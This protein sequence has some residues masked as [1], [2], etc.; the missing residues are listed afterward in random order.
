[1]VTFYVWKGMGVPLYIKVYQCMLPTPPEQTQSLSVACPNLHHSMQMGINLLLENYPFSI[2]QS[3][4]EN[5]NFL[6]C[7]LFS[8]FSDFGLQGSVF[9]HVLAILLAMNYFKV[10]KH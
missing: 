9:K 4:P 7:P 6:T 5:E 10:P 3:T 2:R 8:H 1:M